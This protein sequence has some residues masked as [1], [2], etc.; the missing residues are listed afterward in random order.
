[1]AASSQDLTFLSVD[2]KRQQEI[3]QE[4][5][6]EAERLDT[7]LTETTISPELKPKLEEI[8]DSLQRVAR[9]LARNAAALST[10]ALIV[11]W[12]VRLY[13]FSVAVS[14]GYLIYRG[15]WGKEDTITSISEIIKIAVIPILTLVIGYYFGSSKAD[16]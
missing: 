2:I 6:E 16:S 12:V 5:S 9:G 15:I 8:K 14:I 13:A 1:M 4:V 10:S 7:L 11:R 3:A